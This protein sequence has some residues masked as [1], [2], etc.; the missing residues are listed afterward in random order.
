LMND[1]YKQ[2]GEEGHLAWLTKQWPKVLDE[3]EMIFLRHF[4]TK[5]L[6]NLFP[7]YIYYAA[8]TRDADAYRA[9]LMILHK[10]SL[11]N[12]NLFMYEC[13]LRQSSDIKKKV[14]ILEEQLKTLTGMVKESLG[15]PKGAV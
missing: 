3:V 11:S 2:C 7:D 9:E 8:P 15:S 4:Q 6:R 14:D 10:E 12:E 1:A 13:T 5:R